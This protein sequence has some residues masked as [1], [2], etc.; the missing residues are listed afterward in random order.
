MYGQSTNISKETENIKVNELG[1]IITEMENSPGRFN[2][3]FK[4]AEDQWS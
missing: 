4:Q 2:S 1:S 3:R